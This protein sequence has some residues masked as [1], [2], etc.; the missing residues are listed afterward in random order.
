[1]DVGIDA[2]ASVIVDDRLKL[3]DVQPAG[4]DV[5]GDQDVYLSG[6]KGLQHRR[7]AH[8]VEVTMDGPGAEALARELGGQ[9]LYL[10]SRAGKHKHLA[11]VH[12]GGKVTREPCP[13]LR[14]RLDNLDTLAQARGR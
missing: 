1:M 11:D 7:P 3:L 6:A 2:F 8:R 4:G 5:G 14:I 10:G 12:Q 9:L 13:L